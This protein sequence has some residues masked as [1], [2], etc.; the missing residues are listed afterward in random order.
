MCRDLD[1]A[2]VIESAARP[3]AAAD[4]VELRFEITR[5]PAL[6]VVA[7]AAGLAQ[8]F[9]NL[10]NNLAKIHGPGPGEDLVNSGRRTAIVRSRTPGRDSGG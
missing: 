4:E 3:A 5:P 10:L 7:T 6:Q 1:P 9:S 8:P 2:E